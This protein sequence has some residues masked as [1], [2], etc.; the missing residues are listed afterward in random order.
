LGI[1]WG[2]FLKGTN[3]LSSLGGFSG[4]N[5]GVVTGQPFL[6]DFPSA[7]GAGSGAG[8]TYGIMN[9]AKTM[10]L[11]FQLAAVETSGTG[12]VISS[13]KLVTSDNVAAK[14]LQGES[15]PY[16]EPA[17]D[18]GG[19]PTTAFKDVALTI[20]VLPHI[21]PANSIFMSVKTIKE[22]LL[23]F[24]QLSAG[25]APRTTKLESSTQVLIENG[26]T[27]VIGGMYKIIERDSISGVPGLMNIPGLGWL[28]KKN[29]KTRDTRELIIFI[30]PR[31]IEKP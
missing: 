9:A 28:F 31:I 13:P 8:F 27:M 30:T 4:L 11:D 23:E 1:Q 17:A 3:T 16:T 7:V 24:V 18:G 5:K 26:E 6:V 20:E 14:L 21:T 29:Q 12:K 10:G 15:I 19:A 25:P 2:G 22:E